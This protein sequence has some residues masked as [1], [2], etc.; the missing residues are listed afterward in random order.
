MGLE[1]MTSRSTEAFAVGIA[2]TGYHVQ[3]IAIVLVSIPPEFG[4]ADGGIRERFD[5]PTRDSLARKESSWVVRASAVN[6]MRA[7]GFR[8]ITWK[9]DTTF[10]QVRGAQTY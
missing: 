2:T 9:M 10:F 1:T 3:D 5:R 4:H 8:M 7:K 6:R